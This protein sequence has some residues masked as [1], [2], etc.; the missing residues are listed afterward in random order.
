MVELSAEQ[1]AKLKA[2]GATQKETLV[3]M[4]DDF[5]KEREKD[6]ACIYT[7]N[8][9]GCRSGGSVSVIDAFRDALA[10]AGLSDRVR[11][12][13]TGCMGLCASG[14][15]ARVEIKGREPF[16]Y[17][18]VTPDLAQIIVAQHIA[19][20]L[21]DAAAPL[22]LS[23]KLAGHEL[24]LKLPFFTKQTKIVLKHLGHSD[25]ENLGEYIANG[26]Y[27]ALMKA[28]EMK[29]ADVIDIVKK[30]GL[31]G[32]GGAG[33]ST[34]LKW[35]MLAKSAPVGGEKFV[36]CNG[37]EGDPGAYMD[38]C[39][40]GGGSHAVLEG[41][42]IAAYATGATSGWFYIRAEYPLALERM[43]LAIRQAKKYGILGRNIFG[44]DFNFMADL[45]YGAGAFVCGEETALM[46][47]LEGNRGTPRPRPPFPTEKGLFDK[48]SVINNVETLATVPA[49]ILGGA[50]WYNAIG[51][52]TSK[53]TKVFALTGKVL[54]SGLVEV[55]FGT[56]I[57]E[58]VN[59]IGGGTST[60]KKF[61]AVQTGGPS[62]GVIPASEFRM[63]LC[64]EE[65]K[66]IGSI[67][68]SGGMIVMDESDSMVEIAKFYLEFTVEESCG[69]CTPCRIGGYQM[70][71][72]LKKIASG[73]GTRADMDKIRDI[74]AAMQRG[75]L[76]GLGQTAPN[77]V[78]STMKFFADEYDA[79]LNKGRKG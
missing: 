60:G 57:G 7:C 32:R 2:L 52:A 55:P 15:L 79:L 31:R 69:K 65:L 28:L 19:P 67:M 39:I 29:P 50:D 62:G 46:A 38:S 13:G 26:G 72:L 48:P 16:L 17:K 33:F 70:L 43:E 4:G 76:C 77:P 78:I 59:D 73:K 42:M 61:K 34:G 10:A 66:K 75:S 1:I 71:R 3:K 63:P 58:M 54:H 21:K 14:P 45:R 35:E 5:K 41:M 53:G 24:S 18:Q 23:K 6:A 11:M 64:Y 68:G 40:L 36:I 37:D 25:P 12:V 74:A 30:S 51:T 47:S 56:T 8:A 22:N 9:T 20:A 49:I 27:R 44:S